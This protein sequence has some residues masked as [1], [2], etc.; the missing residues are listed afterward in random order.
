MFM[1]LTSLLCNNWRRKKRIHASGPQASGF[2][3]FFD[4]APW[5]L[6]ASELLPGAS[7]P[8]PRRQTVAAHLPSSS[9]IRNV[10]GA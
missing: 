1:V 4:P 6:I 3:L 10:H 9:I 5:R 2:I 8:N 7:A